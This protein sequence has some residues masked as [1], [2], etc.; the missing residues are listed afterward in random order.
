MVQIITLLIYFNDCEKLEF[1]LTTKITKC[2]S[3][4]TYFS[5]INKNISCDIKSKQVT[6]WGKKIEL[7]HYPK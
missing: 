2:I 4:M 6:L 1:E 7:F 5:S 3:F